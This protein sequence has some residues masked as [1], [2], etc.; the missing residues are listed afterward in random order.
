L[1]VARSHRSGELGFS[2]AGRQ[3]IAARIGTVATTGVVGQSWR[4]RVTTAGTV[5]PS[6]GSPSL[7]WYVY[8]G[9][10]WYDPAGRAGVRH[11]RARGTAVF[12]TRMRIPG[13]DAVQRVWSVADQGGYTL[14]SVDN[15]S[16]QAIAVAFG[17]PTVATVRPP[18]TVPVEGIEL[19]TGS[20]VLPLGHRAAVTVGIA[21]RLSGASTL[22]GDLPDAP[23]V[24]NGWIASADRASRLQLPQQALVDAVRA[25]RCELLLGGLI[26][27]AIDPARYLL[28]I[29]ELLRLGELGPRLA[30]DVA[31]DVASAATSVARQR[32]PLRR[33]A[34]AAAAAV[35]HAAGEHRAVADVA[36]L[37]AAHHDRRPSPRGL[38]VDGDIAAVIAVEGELND[39]PALFPAGIPKAWRGQDFEAHDLVAGPAS[40]LSLA[41]R[42]HG[43]NPALL[44]EVEGGEVTLTADTG[45]AGGRGWATNERRG[46]VLWRSVGAGP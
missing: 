2:N 39:G 18:A 13:G 8:A 33:A 11:Q 41:V 28:G 29:A 37:R 42:W 31:L 4:A 34:L 36:R 44:W 22:P 15:E 16:P 10:S 17:G 46:E 26:D 6:D 5:E 12:E 40:R 32:D 38:P 35:L 23:A 25:A 7:R 27:A 1:A 21:H 14:V 45:V 43:A 9:D 30:T 19:P 20:V 24:A 3:L